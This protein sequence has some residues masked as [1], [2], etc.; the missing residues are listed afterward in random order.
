MRK[1]QVEPEAWEHFRH[2]LRN[3]RRMLDRIMRLVEECQRDPFGGI[4]KP[5]P[6]KGGKQGFWSRR[7]D[8]EHRLVYKVTDELVIVHSA[9]GHYDN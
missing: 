6:L 7:I 8:Q 1:L 9:L 4:G 5:E 3:D 2:W